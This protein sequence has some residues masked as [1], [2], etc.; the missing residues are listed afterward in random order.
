MSTSTTSNKERS[1]TVNTNVLIHENGS[2]S[3]SQNYNIKIASETSDDNSNIVPSKTSLTNS[4][5]KSQVTSIKK[6][7]RAG[8]KRSNQQANTKATIKSNSD[9]F[10]PA[11]M[12]QNLLK[13]DNKGRSSFVEK[14]ITT[15]ELNSTPKTYNCKDFVENENLLCIQKVEILKKIEPPLLVSDTSTDVIF[16]EAQLKIQKELT[17]LIN[18]ELELNILELKNQVAL[19]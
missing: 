6:T 2:K 11:C 19:L 12:K 15:A 8:F 7:G 13:N 9:N 14:K 1:I 16:N 18:Q 5:T 4:Y 10:Y 17:E 3:F